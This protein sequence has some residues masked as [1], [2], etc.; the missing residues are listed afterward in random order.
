MF[1]LAIEFLNALV[2][3]AEL[4]AQQTQHAVRSADNPL[5][6][7]AFPTYFAHCVDTPA[8]ALPLPVDAPI[9]VGGSGRWVRCKAAS[10]LT[11][12]PSASHFSSSML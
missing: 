1:T 12:R 3:A 4:S 9:F 8:L 11:N 10:L 2:S 6:G 5:L 7:A